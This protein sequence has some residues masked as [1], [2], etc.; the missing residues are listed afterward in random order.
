VGRDLDDYEAKY[1]ALPFEAMQ[2]RY[3]RLKTLETIERYSPAKV[4][5]IGCGLEPLFL[6]LPH[7]AE[8]T[9]VEPA[10]A[11]YANAAR[12]ANGRANVMIIRGTLDSQT[13]NLRGRDY[14]LIL[15]SSLL[16]E[17]DDPSSMLK[18][19]RALCN[20]GT[21]VHIVVPNAHSLH[22]L[23]AVEMGL[24]DDVYQKS[25]T[26]IAMQQA[27]TFSVSSLTTLVEEAGFNV[28][29]RET[30]FVKPFTHQQMARCMDTGIVTGPMLDGLYRLASRLPDYGS[31]ICMNLRR[32]A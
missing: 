20:S 4:L 12:A 26:Q 30:F 31:E 29:E 22:R 23:L 21:V 6:Y 7:V 2:I 17:V 13:S 15:V 3:R 8:Y 5:E 11:F 32:S 24:I 14:D 1:Q 18:A 27:S 25:A 10:E 16:H 19:V 9:V 28:M